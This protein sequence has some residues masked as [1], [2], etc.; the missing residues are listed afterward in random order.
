M[1]SRYVIYQ[2][3]Q[4]QQS[5]TPSS[6]ATFESDNGADLSLLLKNLLLNE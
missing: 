1:P 6:E 5:A 4:S 2:A 3:A